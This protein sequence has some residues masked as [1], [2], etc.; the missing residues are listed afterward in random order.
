MKPDLK[1][2]RKIM[3]ETQLASRGISDRKV[4]DAFMKVERHLFVPENLIE[5]AYADHPLPIG[6]GQTISQPYMVALMTE[7]LELN[8]NDT[9]LEIGTG[10]G[11]QLAI[12]SVLSKKVYSIERFPDLALKAGETLKKM[13]FK[14]FEIKTGDGTL[15][16]P[17]NAPYDAIM[18]T[19]A[20]PDVPEAYAEQLKIGG[21]LLMPVGEA[22]LQTLVRMTKTDSGVKTEEFGG[23][24]FVPLI[25]KKGWK[26]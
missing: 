8:G 6:E 22:F 10:S 9:V 5:S 3:V 11:Y 20:A 7:L 23:C 24:T 17:E 15:G 25:G 2:Q 14:N 16:W 19:A 21:R 12:L 18:V 4:L 13:N 1:T 26:H